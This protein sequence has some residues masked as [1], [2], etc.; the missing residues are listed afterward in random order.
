M[1]KTKR[2]ILS[3]FLAFSFLLGLSFGVNRSDASADYY[4]GNSSSVIGWYDWNDWTWQYDFWQNQAE[5]GKEVSPWQF[6][7]GAWPVN[8]SWLRCNSKGVGWHYF[9]VRNHTY[10]DGNK[11]SI[12]FDIYLEWW[13]N[14]GSWWYGWYQS[15]PQVFIWPWNGPANFGAWNDTWVWVGNDWDGWWDWRW[16]NW[17]DF[18]TY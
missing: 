2:L 10:V 15:L 11:I 4:W 17:T 16:T 13:Q 3:T 1:M 9:C 7:P 12:S 14:Q 6:A 5:I 8:L 18:Y